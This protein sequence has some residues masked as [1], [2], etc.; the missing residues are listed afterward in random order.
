MKLHLYGS[1]RCSCPGILSCRYGKAATALCGKCIPPTHM[2]HYVGERETLEDNK[3]HRFPNRRCRTCIKVLD[4]FL[5]QAE[6]PPPP[7]RAPPPAQPPTRWRRRRTAST[8]YQTLQAFY[9]ADP[10][11]GCSPEADYGVHWRQH[12]WPG[13]WRVSYVKAT[14]EVYALHQDQGPLLVPGLGGAGPPGNLL[15]HPRT[16]PGRLA[17][18]LR[19]T[20]RPGLGEG[21]P[22]RIILTREAFVKMNTSDRGGLDMAQEMSIYNYDQDGALIITHFAPD[23]VTAACGVYILDRRA[24]W[25]EEPGLV[26]GC[27]S[28]LHAAAQNAD[29][30]AEPGERQPALLL[31]PRRRR[32]LPLLQPGLC[33]G[34]GRGGW[35]VSRPP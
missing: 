3:Y 34:Q 6:P 27:P 12:P 9:D 23:T 18:R 19:P 17:S 30:D 15:H 1:P 22:G 4:N 21:T 32:R 5:L 7:F 28:C 8:L 13:T 25:T 10:R 26:E 24:A 14:G 16:D 35:G 11:R 20:Q 31:L 29:Q 2:F 33:Q